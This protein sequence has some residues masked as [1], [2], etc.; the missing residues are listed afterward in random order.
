MIWARLSP[1]ELLWSGLVE[2]IVEG[3]LEVPATDA[4]NDVIGDVLD[5]RVL[6]W[7]EGNL[8]DAAESQTVGDV[9]DI[10]L[11]IPDLAD[12]A[13]GDLE[14]VEQL[15]LVRELPRLT[16]V[17]RSR[18]HP[19]FRVWPE[20]LIKDERARHGCMKTRDWT[21]NRR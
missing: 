12:V 18:F 19:V 15:F 9:M 14:R 17:L 21:V 3:L 10:A 8:V 4:G 6:D 1:F 7:P 13:D 2:Q 20:W 16:L 5:D 11:E